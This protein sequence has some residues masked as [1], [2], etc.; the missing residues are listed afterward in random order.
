MAGGTLP[1]EETQ[2][3]MAGGFI[4]QFGNSVNNPPYT[5]AP[6]PSNEP[7]DDCELCQQ[8]LWYSVAVTYLILKVLRP[9]V[10]D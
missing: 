1:W 4:L 9:F 7:Y 6:N 5:L 10:D 2:G 3:S 8:V